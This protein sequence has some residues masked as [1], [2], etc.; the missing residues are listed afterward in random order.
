MD[1]GQFRLSSC[2]LEKVSAMAHG[3][4]CSCG[5]IRGWL[6]ADLVEPREA[7]SID[8]GTRSYGPRPNHISPRVI[9][10]RLRACKMLTLSLIKLPKNLP[11]FFFSHN[12]MFETTLIYG[13]GVELG[14]KGTGSLL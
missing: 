11:F 5:T 12:A 6:L 4:S 1:E 3:F 9:E 10:P 2:G 13:E 14:C 8:F 7:Q